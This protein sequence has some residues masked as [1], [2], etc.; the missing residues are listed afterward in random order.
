MISIK[1]NSYLAID[2]DFFIK[3]SVKVR[4]IHDLFGIIKYLPETI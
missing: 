3:G 1:N 4:M 2:L